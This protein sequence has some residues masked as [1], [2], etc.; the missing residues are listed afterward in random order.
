MTTHPFRFGAKATRATS[1]SEWQE[2]AR[3]AEDL[4]YASFQIDDHFGNQL[5]PVPA[6][7][8]AAAATSTILVG[9]H[10]AGVDFRNPVLFA[11]EAATIDLLSDGRFTLGLGA[12][13]SADDYAIAGIEQA[14]ASVRIERLGEAIAIMRGL[15]GDGAFSFTGK[16]YSV[17][18]V[19]AKPKPVSPIPIMVGGGGRKLLTLAAQSAD[20][21]GIN[22]KIV[23]RSINPR[24]MSTAA[25]DVVDEKIG[26]VREGAGDRFDDIELQLQIFKTVVTD[27]PDAIIGQ[28]ATAFGLPPEVVATA[29]FFQIGTVEQ[30]TEN[31]IAMRE[32]WGISYIVFQND[33]TIPM[34]PIVAKL[35][36]T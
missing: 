26:Y 18:E 10:V 29:P 4:G 31:L 22:P 32:R 3:T 23:G 36:G 12:G 8:A 21:V 5:A 1:A 16:H 20:I 17:A 35:A 6:I 28:L 14:S 13:W 15:W 24:S 7:M 27:Q 30:I 33:G 34:A 25:A 19:D 11:K 2:L 9:P